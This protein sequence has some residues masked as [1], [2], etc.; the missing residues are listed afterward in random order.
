VFGVWCIR[1]LAENIYMSHRGVFTVIPAQAGIQGNKPIVFWIPAF[2]GMTRLLRRNAPSL[3]NVY[4]KKKKTRK[5]ERTKN[6]VF[7]KDFMFSC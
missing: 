4:V 1:I 7:F 5:H 6:L 3:D 2:A